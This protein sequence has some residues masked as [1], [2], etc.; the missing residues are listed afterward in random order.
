M[1]LLVRVASGSA[2]F[3][4]SR[5]QRDAAARIGD[6]DG[7]AAHRGEAPLPDRILDH[8]RHEV[9]AVAD[10]VEPRLRSH[11]ARAGRRA[12]RRSCRRGGRRGAARGTR[13]RARSCPP[14]RER[15]LPP[16][17]S[18]TSHGRSRRPGGS[19]RLAAGEVERRD[20]RARAAAL[21]TI[22]ET[23]SRSAAPSP[24]TAA[25]PGRAPS[26]AAVDDDRDARSLVGGAVADDELVA[27]GRRGEPC[28][29]EPVDRRD[30][31]AGPVRPRA[32]HVAAR[33]SA[34]AR[35]VAERQPGQAAARNEREGAPL[36][37]GHA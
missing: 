10:R 13:A 33:P 12:R 5:T 22:D 18:A 30:R 11:A 14:A 27:A 28:R 31:I 3:R 26:R 8:H 21:A 9:P 17:R 20:V 19:P 25:A 23:A 16:C 37:N 32:D 24:A 2:S 35:Q 7:H 6:R 36:A 29:R 15:C 4:L 34:P 1:T